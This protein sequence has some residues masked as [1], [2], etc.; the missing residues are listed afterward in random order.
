MKSG[1]VKA[2]E[3]EKLRW[4]KAL[5]K[6]LAGIR[7]KEWLERA[8][9]EAAI[10]GITVDEAGSL[11]PKREDYF[12]TEEK[13]HDKVLSQATNPL[14]VGLKLDLSKENP[15]IWTRK[16]LWEIITGFATRGKGESRED[17]KG[18]V[19][20]AKAPV[21]RVGSE[22]EALIKEKDGSH[23]IRDDVDREDI[24]GIRVLVKTPLRSVK[25]KSLLAQAIE[26]G[27]AKKVGEDVIELTGVDR[28]RHKYKEQQGYGESVEDRIP[29]EFGDY[30]ELEMVK[31][32]VRDALTDMA[33]PRVKKKLFS[34]LSKH[35]RAD[36]DDIDPKL[37]NLP[38]YVH[39][40]LTDEEFADLRKEVVATCISEIMYNRGDNEDSIR[41]MLER[42]KNMEEITKTLGVTKEE[43][44]D[45]IRHDWSLVYHVKTAKGRNEVPQSEL[46]PSLTEEELKTD[47]DRLVDKII[48]REHVREM[49][50]K[51]AERYGEDYEI[52]GFHVVRKLKPSILQRR[53]DEKYT[54]EVEH[55]EHLAVSPKQ[56]AF[57]S[58]APGK[59]IIKKKVIKK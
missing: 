3:E 42:K 26:S 47:T 19:H 23:V 45:I 6:V 14:L 40:I 10:R 30:A 4:E 9:R 56:E 5:D 37:Q 59:P 32:T 48:N 44:D 34:L 20:I 21:R 2:R 36:V 35:Q 31:N 12:H 13:L 43:V 53:L 46:Y 54:E 51:M 52:D 7:E 24:R 18:V 58:Y 41:G 50:H 55:G 8:Q 25:P 39:T 16:S 29:P 33:M 17:V 38:G 28:I 57:R 22:V 49:N 27:K 11:N 1:L 15:E